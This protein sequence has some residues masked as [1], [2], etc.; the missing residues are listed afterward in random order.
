MKPDAFVVKGEVLASVYGPVNSRRHGLSLGIN[1]GLTEHKICTWSC[2][3]CQC[4]FG[5]RRDYTTEEKRI[6]VDDLLLMI[7]SEALRHF[8]L[9]AITL[10]GNTE[11]GTYPQ[12]L[13][14][15]KGLKRLKLAS[16]SKW[17]I[18]VL[19][20]GSELDH[21]EV[22]HAF[23]LADEVWFKID[24]GTE[25]LFHIL[26]R[27]LPKVGLLKDHL[28]RLKKISNLKIQTMIWDNDK[29][30]RLSNA[31]EENFDA[32]LACYAELNPAQVHLTTVARDPALPG[33]I[34]VSNEVL[35]AFADRIRIKNIST[36]VLI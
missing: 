6:S 13:E 28:N 24:T 2:L 17:K 15:M 25:E 12:I 23:N 34:P 33:V 29:E 16:R 14:L 4:G 9:A 27:P 3:Y 5:E 19:S 26:N 32:L 20:N 30:P 31:T 18:I 11:P 22:V 8:D 10:A 1:V 36:E 21:P 7:R 35:Q